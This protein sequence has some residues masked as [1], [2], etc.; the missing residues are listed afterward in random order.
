MTRKRAEAL[1]HEIEASMML[2]TW[3]NAKF[4]TS[5]RGYACQI[6]ALLGEL[7]YGLDSLV[8]ALA[9]NAEPASR[10]QWF[11][12]QSL[13]IVIPGIDPKSFCRF[14][15]VEEFEFIFTLQSRLCAIWPFGLTENPIANGPQAVAAF[16]CPALR[17]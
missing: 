3:S 4:I 2:K 16:G 17:K 11:F 7:N 14:T 9:H 10:V 12:L 1:Q 6:D 5:T 8:V 13:P 15:G